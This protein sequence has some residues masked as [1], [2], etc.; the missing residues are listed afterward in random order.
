MKKA[1]KNLSLDTFKI[2]KLTQ[3]LS[4]IKGGVKHH[5]A[6]NET[7]TVH[8]ILTNSSLRCASVTSKQC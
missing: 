8:G 2:A 5:K 7:S 6:S 1:Q 4:Y 3:N